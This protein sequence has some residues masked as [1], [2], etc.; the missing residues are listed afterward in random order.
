M[1]FMKPF[2]GLHFAI[3]RKKFGNFIKLHTP[4]LRFRYQL[5]K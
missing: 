5:I 2:F 3:E 4:V 1:D